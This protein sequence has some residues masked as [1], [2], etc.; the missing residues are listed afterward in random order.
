MKS[1]LFPVFICFLFLFNSIN[2]QIQLGSDLD[3]EAQGDYFGSALSLSSDGQFLA[4]GADQ[5]DGGGMDAG[6]VR[7]FQKSGSTWVQR[8]GDIDSPSGGDYFGTSVAISDDGNRV[9]IGSKYSNVNGGASGHASVFSYNGSSWSQLGTD[10]DGE[11][12]F[13]Y[14]GYAVDMS[15][16]GNTIAIGATHNDGSGNQDCGHARVYSYSGGNW[17]QKGGDIDGE[18]SL[19]NSGWSVS[20]SSDGSRIA[21][22]AYKNQANGMDAGHVRVYTF[23]SGN[24]AQVGADIDGGVDDRFGWDVALSDDGYTVVVG[25]THNTNAVGYQAGVTRVYKL[26]G[27]SW[28]QLGQDL[29]GESLVD[30]FGYSVA[31]SGDGT[32]IASG[33]IRNDGT[34]PDGGTVKVFQLVGTSWSQIGTDIDSENAGD[35]FGHAVSLSSDGSIVAIGAL[36]NNPS[37]TAPYTGHVRCFDLTGVLSSD[38]EVSAPTDN[39]RVFPNPSTGLLTLELGKMID[40]VTVTISNVTGKVLYQN[41]F[42]QIETTQLELSD[43]SGVYFVKIEMPDQP[44]KTVRVVKE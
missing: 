40:Q 2:A 6:H 7:V 32:V 42:E 15:D 9:V 20:L 43:T 38:E 39:V 3:G 14:A 36:N 13:D 24:W 27:G 4:V 19:D 26:V 44:A 10:I 31:I 17:V 18:A 35:W 11:A 16:D 21:I 34:G 8:G 37:G 5:N 29:V 28:T 1:L 22:G 41:N 25:A 30:W 12:A 33:A 23:T